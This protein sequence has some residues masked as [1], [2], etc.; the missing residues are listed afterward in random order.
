LFEVNSDSIDFGIVS[1]GDSSISE[2]NLYNSKDSTVTINE[3]LIND[4][5]F[6]VLN[7]LPISIPPQDSV[8]LLLKFKPTAEG[9][10]I[11]KLNVR[12]VTDTLLIGKQVKLIGTTSLVSVEGQNNSNFQF[13]LSQNFPNPFNP[14]TTIKYKIP[15]RSFV[16]IKI[17]DIL[18]NEVATL[19]NEEKIQG[20]YE[21]KFDGISL[22]S[23]IYFYQL[24]TDSFFKTK[25]MMMLK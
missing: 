13:S 15:K 9:Y 10:Y 25:K 14:T 18:G 5:S 12:F 1:V 21:V 3:F 16:T 6:S 23:G 19:V 2:L 7:D 20:S 8:T 4:S 11:D 17:Y 22:T 24:K